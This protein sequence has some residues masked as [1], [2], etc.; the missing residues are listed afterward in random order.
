MCCA[1]WHQKIVG[2]MSTT[3]KRFVLVHCVLSDFVAMFCLGRC[4]L[5]LI[6]VL[7]G[8]CERGC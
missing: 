6:V 1:Q 2:I 3:G 8:Q 7:L 4:A 5:D